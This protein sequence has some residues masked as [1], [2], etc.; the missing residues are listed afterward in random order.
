[1][2]TSKLSIFA[3]KLDFYASN[4]VILILLLLVLICPKKSVYVIDDYL[5]NYIDNYNLNEVT[6]SEVATSKEVERTNEEKVSDILVKYNLTMDQFNV[7]VAVVMAEA[8]PE[9]YDDA[10][11]VIN[12]IYNRTISKN[13]AYSIKNGNNL[14]KQVIR[15]G[16]FSVYGSGIYKKYLNNTTFPAYQAVID[17]LDS[18]I[19]IHDYLSFKANFVKIVG[20]QLY[21]NGNIYHNLMQEE[22]LISDEYSLVSSINA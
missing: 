21:E 2:I 11:A 7:I 18:E 13:W 16:Q 9:C 3:S 12:T 22:D 17:F 5:S 6:S 15:T 20:E 8:G 10:Y 1:M 4:K 19:R 14:Y